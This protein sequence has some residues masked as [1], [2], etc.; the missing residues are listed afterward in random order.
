MNSKHKSDYGEWKLTAGNF[1]G[2]A[3]KDKGKVL[4]F[5]IP[6]INQESDLIICYCRRRC[7]HYDLKTLVIKSAPNV[8]I[9]FIFNFSNLVLKP[10]KITVKEHIMSVSTSSLSTTAEIF[11]C[12]KQLPLLCSMS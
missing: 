3:E 9:E 2:D 4:I 6:H 1:Y 11:T 10:N 7:I 5:L 8:N 12:L